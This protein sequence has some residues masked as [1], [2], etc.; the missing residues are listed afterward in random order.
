[1]R[2]L[3]LAALVGIGATAD[4]QNPPS[5]AP[6]APGGRGG[7]GR[8]V[9]LMTL[10]TGSFADG[11]A[12]P[13]TYSQSG[14]EKS[15]PL[16]WSGVPDSVASFVLVMHDLDAPI[17]SGADDVLHWLL[18]NIP[19]TATS[20]PEGVQ[21]TSQLPDGTRQISASGPY[22]RGPGAAASG[23]THHYVFEL[24]AL[25][26]M[27]DVAPVGASPAATRQAVMAAMA[28]HIRAKGVLVGLY[29]RPAVTTR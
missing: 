29:K 20:L 10:T 2:V 21:A 1:M 5:G 24:Y 9:R 18:W 25:D 23:P 19:G 22:Y 6:P 3:I 14:D 13:A 15:P 8:A 4:A 27:L 11:G 28:G 16:S 7:R 26:T 12:I 17:A